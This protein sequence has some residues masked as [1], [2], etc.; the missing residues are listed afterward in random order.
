MALNYSF[1]KTPE[2]LAYVRQLDP[3]SNFYQQEKLQ[4]FWTVDTEVAKHVLPPHVE[5]YMPFGVPIVTAYIAD[6]GRPEFLYPYTEGALF[7]LARCENVIGVYCLSMPLDGSDQAQDGGREFYGYPKKQAYV[8]LERRG[9]KVQGYIIRNDVKIFEADATIGETP[10]NP[11]ACPFVLGPEGP[12]TET[13][14]VILLKY[15]LD[16]APVPGK[17]VKETRFIDCF[18]NLR[19]QAQLNDSRMS[20]KKTARVDRMTF[21]PS[22]DDP[23]I[24]LAPP[25]EESIFGAYFC[26]FDTF[27]GA[28]EDVYFYAP[29][30]YESVEPYLFLAYDTPFLGKEHSSHRCENFQNK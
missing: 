29:E 22:E 26:K 25:S 14:K 21:R 19:I 13:G 30:E 27:M 28:S 15:S 8:K 1:V 11:E 9:D 10:N 12:R 24:E 20:F 16:T 6:F 2:E 17:T 7:M 3:K 23:W 18:R 4:V 5:P